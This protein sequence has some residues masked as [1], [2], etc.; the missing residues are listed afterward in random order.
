MR[1]YKIYIDENMPAQLAKGLN[2]LQKPQNLKDGFEI[3]VLSIKE[4]FGQG[5]LDEEWIPKLGK[6]KGIVITQDFNIQNTKHQRELYQ[7]SGV[8]IFFLKT[9]SKN[10]FQYWDFVKKMIHEWEAI[11]KIIKKES[12]PF[13]YRGSSNK[14][15]E[16]MEL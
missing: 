14:P 8:G 9:P 1:K 12:V 16:K 3:E 15:F 2:E 11:K 7:N 13:A 10:G 5:A 4:V 6:E